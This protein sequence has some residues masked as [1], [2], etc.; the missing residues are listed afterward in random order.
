MP[1]QRRDL[2]RTPPGLASRRAGMRPGG[3]NGEALPPE[4]KLVH[5][6]RTVIYRKMLPSMGDLGKATAMSNGMRLV[7]APRCEELKQRHNVQT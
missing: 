2:D 6:E 3:Q 5:A 4:S 7:G 1:P